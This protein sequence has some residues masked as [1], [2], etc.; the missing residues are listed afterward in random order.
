MHIQGIARYIPENKVRLIDDY[1]RWKL[2]QAQAKVYSKIYGIE[3]IPVAT[4]M[5]LIELLKR[6][7]E[8][9]IINCKIDKTQIKILIHTHTAQVVAPFG[10]SAI[11]SVK[12]EVELKNAIAFGVSMNNCASIFDAF[13]LATVLLEKL[14]ENAQAII[15]TG[16]LAFTPTM[17]VIPNTSLTGDAAVAVLISKNKAGHKL[18]S[19]TSKI[20]GDY[21]KGIWLCSE[22]SAE[23]EKK[24]AVLLAETIKDVVTKAGL[25]LDD[26]KIIFPHN[27]N[28]VSWVNVA[29]ALKINI[30]KVYTKNIRKYAHCFGADTLINYTSAKEEGLLQSGDYFLMASVGLGATFGAAVFC[31]EYE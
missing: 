6:P 7:I 29:N 22:K 27:V 1:S 14:D 8:E 18:I 24:Y 4:D 17:Q 28:L 31:C 21:S 10:R 15:V 30:N 3:H 5:S 25:T 11:R 2:T 26:L 19:Q 13:E 9:L 20:Y 16:E 12:Q 23:F